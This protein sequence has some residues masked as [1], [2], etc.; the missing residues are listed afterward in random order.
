MKTTIKVTNEELFNAKVV[1][2]DTTDLVGLNGTL[3]IETAEGV[4]ELTGEHGEKDYES[5]FGL[6]LVV[7]I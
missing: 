6:V 2:V 1:D 7:E 4:K 5:E 3:A